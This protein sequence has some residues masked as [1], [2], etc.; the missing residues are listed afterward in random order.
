LG[1]KRGKKMSD[2][3]F[4]KEPDMIDELDSAIDEWDD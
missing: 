2:E 4:R 3:E 1:I